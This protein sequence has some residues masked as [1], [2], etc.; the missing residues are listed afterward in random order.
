MRL[1]AVASSLESCLQAVWASGR[2]KAGL[3]TR[4]L[5]QALRP[6]AASLPLACLVVLGAEAAGSN[7]GSD[8]GLTKPRVETRAELGKKLAELHCAACHL[9]PAPELLDMKTWKEQTLPRMAFRMGLAPAMFEKYPDA[10]YIRASGVIPG[11]P[12]VSPDEFKQMAAYYLETA[13]EKA[14]PQD[15]RNRIVVGLDNFAFDPV[16]FRHAPPSTTLVHISQPTR[17]IYF[18]DD[19]SKSLNVLDSSGGFIDS[20]K[21]QNVP[22]SLTETA[23]GIYLTMIGRFIPSEEP[24]G[25]LVFLRRTEQSFEPAKTFFK[26]MPRMTD[27]VFADVNHDGKPDIVTCYFGYFSGRFGWYENLGKDEFREHVLLPKPGAVRSVVQDLNGDGF[28]DIAVLVAQETESLFIFINDG[29]G[30]F[31]SQTVFQQPP[32]YGHTHF[33]VVDFDR[34]GR[35]DFLVS[36]GD[37]G[38]YPSPIKK[39]HGVRLYLNKS[40]HRFEQS[41]FYPLNGAFK[42]TAHDFD[43]DDDLDIAAISYFPD[44]ENSPEEGFVYLENLGNRRFAASTFRQCLA[45]RWLTMDVGD[46]DSDGDL[47]IV[48]GSYIRGPSDVPQKLAEDWERAGPSV[49]ILRNR[50]K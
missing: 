13:P 50:L 41:F 39:Y 15:R 27:A 46:L 16:R 47:D 17:R 40:E 1:G 22:V 4:I 33:E 7:Q 24:L 6:A 14:R 44:Y 10:E 20:V 26:N 43:G 29:K 23:R 45:G 35:P 38:E 36:N 19:A 25:G 48:L 49:A 31:A 34:D 30:N 9:F 37:N 21:V 28:R 2:L 42:A 12:M 8:S 32:I 3:Q 18:G 11:A 5:R